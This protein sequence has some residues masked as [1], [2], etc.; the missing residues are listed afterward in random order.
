MPE[1]TQSEA[2]AW[3]SV[4]ANTAE[5]LR[6]LQEGLIGA[7]A[8]DVVTFKRHLR[9]EVRH[10][11]GVARQMLQQV[12]RGIHA[13][14]AVVVYGNPRGWKRVKGPTGR[15]SRRVYAIEY[16]HTKD[17]ADYRHDFS[18][19]VDMYFAGG[20]GSILLSRPDGRPLSA[21]FDV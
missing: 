20:D 15:M 11:E 17:G 2:G 5:L 1:R 10:I 7:T 14:P 8:A 16:K 3:R 13:N 18:P 4:L 9:V 19:G 6:S 12:E 21:E